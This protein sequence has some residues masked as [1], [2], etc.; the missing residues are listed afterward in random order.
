M[1]AL[2]DKPVIGIAYFNGRFG[3]NLRRD[4]LICEVVSFNKSRSAQ[5]MGILADLLSTLLKPATERI[6]SEVADSLRSS[7]NQPQTELAVE[8]ELLISPT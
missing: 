2:R 5:E 7:H 4:G 8:V 1:S 3:Q 6:G